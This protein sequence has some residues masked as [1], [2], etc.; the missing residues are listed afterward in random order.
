MEQEFFPEGGCVRT[1]EPSYRVFIFTKEVTEDVKSVNI[2]WSTIDSTCSIELTNPREKWIITEN[3]LNGIWREDEKIKKAIYKRK[4]TFIV[5]KKSKSTINKN[6]NPKSESSTTHTE[7]GTCVYDLYEGDSVISCGDTVRVYL[8][9][10]FSDYWYRGFTGYASPVTDS[11]SADADHFI[12]TVHCEDTKR[13][14]RAT[15]LGWGVW[16]SDS[17][18]SY[19]TQEETEKATVSSIWQYVAPGKSLEELVVWLITGKTLDTSVIGDMQIKPDKEEELELRCGNFTLGKRWVIK[20]NKDVED[21]QLF[22]FNEC[23]RVQGKG[24]DAED[25]ITEEGKFVTRAGSGENA[26]KV[27]DGSLYNVDGQI[28]VMIPEYLTYTGEDE[29][30]GGIYLK[31]HTMLQEIGYRDEYSSRLGII[32][33]WA[34]TVEFKFYALPNGDVL[35]EFPQ[36]DFRPEDYGKANDSITKGKEVFKVTN[37]EIMGWDITEDDG[38]ID[39]LFVVGGSLEQYFKKIG[40]S[41]QLSGRIGIS[42]KESLTKR[43]GWRCRNLDAPLVTSKEGCVLLA[44]ALLNRSFSEAKTMNV[45]CTARYEVWPGRP[46]L[47]EGRRVLGYCTSI[48]HTI[49]W[50]SQLKTKI[51][52][53]YLRGWNTEKEEWTT[54]GGK[55]I[56]E[57]RRYLDY[58]KLYSS[59]KKGI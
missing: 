44:E 53:S 35:L 32:Q 48:E 12:L 50:G 14:I 18:V 33:D 22:L 3:N 9:D 41:A 2:T 16:G 28:H 20:N 15:R 52:L 40:D 43:F 39:T 25:L 6:E 19:A 4:K 54:I 10:P 29:E 27:D 7:A 47:V 1:G 5:T 42:G 56:S 55:L 57:E 34:E 30:E 51:N 46:Y 36:Y 23:L 58:S 45:D 26:K 8:K 31:P 37:K 38:G 11:Y 59:E 24:A 21:A 17:S 13:W 49:V